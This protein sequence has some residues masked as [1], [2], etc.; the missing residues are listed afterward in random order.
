MVVAGFPRRIPVAHG[1]SIDH[2]VVERRITQRRSCWR[3]AG[4]IVARRRQ[5]GTSLAVDTKP[6]LRSEID[7]SL[8]V[9]RACQM[10]VQVTALGDLP[11]ER[12]QEQRLLTDGVEI[13]GCSLFRGKTGAGRGRNRCADDQRGNEEKSNSAHKTSVVLETRIV[14]AWPKNRDRDLVTNPKLRTRHGL[15]RDF[16]NAGTA[17]VLPPSC[18]F[19]LKIR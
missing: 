5:E 4:R 16:H 9:D 10:V 8:G 18:K 12:E 7:Q 6:R 1:K 3:F 17:G 11:Q 14:P 2:F 19:L 15:P 13:S